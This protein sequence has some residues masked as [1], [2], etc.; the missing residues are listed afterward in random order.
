[1]PNSEVV[2]SFDHLV[3]PVDQGG[4]QIKAE[5]LC[6]PEIDRQLES[7]RGLYGKLVRCLAPQ[8][9]IRVRQQTAS[10]FDHLVGSTD[11]WKRHRDAEC[12]GCLEV[13]GQLDFAYLLN[14]QIG[15]FV[16]P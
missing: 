9:F 16:A 7:F 13:D 5:R 11:Q 15:G 8:N 6:G 4:R 12:F 14:R 10:L 1:M 2:A 3:R